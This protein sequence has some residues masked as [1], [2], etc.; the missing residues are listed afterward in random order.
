[1]AGVT[2][3]AAPPDGYLS[4]DEYTDDFAATYAFVAD[5][6]YRRGMKALRLAPTLE[7]YRALMAGQRVPRE[8]LNPDWVRRY[9]L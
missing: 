7:V 3:R 6:E 1:M 9:R 4:W 2:Q 8:A 5:T